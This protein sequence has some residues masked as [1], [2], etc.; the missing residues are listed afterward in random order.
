MLAGCTETVLTPLR[1]PLLVRRL[2][3]DGHQTDGPITM[4]VEPVEVGRFVNRA[5]FS[6]GTHPTLAARVVTAPPVDGN[7]SIAPDIEPTLTGTTRRPRFA[8]RTVPTLPYGSFWIEITNGSRRALFLSP[9]ALTLVLGRRRFHAVT[10]EEDAVK[11]C[12]ATLSAFPRGRLGTPWID[13]ELET[14]HDTLPLFDKE[15]EIAPGDTWRGFALFEIGA[16]T[17]DAYDGALAHDAAEL[18]L[19]VDGTPAARVRFRVVSAKLPALCL[20]GTNRP[21]AA[22]CEVLVSPQSS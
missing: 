20:P 17:A 1:M 2:V 5:A 7:W 19:T 14:M 11:L 9:A 15:L 10:R 8:A 16:Y 3:Q 6:D 21:S 4:N 22:R 18:V 13:V 12:A